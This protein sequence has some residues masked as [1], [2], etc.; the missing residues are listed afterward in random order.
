MIKRYLHK[1]SRTN[2]SYNPDLLKNIYYQWT[3]NQRIQFDSS[4][5]DVIVK[6][7]S[8]LD[9]LIFQL[10]YYKKP[11]LFRIKSPRPKN[12]SLYIYGDVG[13]GKSM[14]MNLFFEA[15]PIQQKTRF[16][17]SKL[18][19]EVHTFIHRSANQNKTEIM[20]A[21]AQKLRAEIQLLCI[22]EFYVTD[23]AD[24]MMLER[25]F[26][27]LFEF[28]VTIVITSNR[29]PNDL[30]RGGIQKAQ[31][32]KFTELLLKKVDVISLDSPKDYRLS[33]LKSSQPVYSFPLG[34][35]SDQFIKDAYA[36]LT[37]NAPITLFQIKLLGRIISLTSAHQDIA[38]TS[39]Y[40]LCEHPL[41]S[42]DYNEIAQHF[43]FI[44]IANIPKMSYEYR[45]EAKRFMTLIDALYEHNVKLICSAEVPAE[46]LYLEGDGSFEF[47]RTISRLI[48]MQTQHYLNQ[49]K[50][51]N[52]NV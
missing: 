18:I 44:I 52:T 42:N 37:G 11:V 17:Y 1:A 20:A 16:H 14:L 29:H 41:G 27:K 2:D 28:N 22:D 7:Q 48:E 46:E 12:P 49:N 19:S 10:E 4:Q 38:L 26:N 50:I 9:K 47:K 39:F 35:T 45:N 21:Y 3:H 43:N 24:A 32:L 6:L 33:Y 8:T 15:C 51:N 30:Y 36:Q 25:L 13:R 5:L 23:I 34:K 40:E 31:F